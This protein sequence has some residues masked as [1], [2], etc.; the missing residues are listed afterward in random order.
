MAID[1]TIRYGHCSR[2]FYVM[3]ITSVALSSFSPKTAQTAASAL[4]V[5]PILCGKIHFVDCVEPLAV[6]N[7]SFI[8]AHSSVPP[9][10]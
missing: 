5:V 7:I 8:H 1:R 9:P 3:F 10:A 2:K 4:A 6:S